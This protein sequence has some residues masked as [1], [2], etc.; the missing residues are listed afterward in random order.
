VY[1]KGCPPSSAEVFL[2]K[3]LMPEKDSLFQF[4]GEISGLESSSSFSLNRSRD[5]QPK[6]DSGDEIAKILGYT[7]YAKGCP[8]SSAEVL[9]SQTLMPERDSLFQFFGEKSG[10]TTFLRSFAAAQ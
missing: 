2:T 4:F 1:A 6:V 8:P 7:V 5:R 10:L 3:I 9:F